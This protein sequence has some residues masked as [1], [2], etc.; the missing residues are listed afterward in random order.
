MYVTL[1]FTRLLQMQNIFDSASK[2]IQCSVQVA[3]ELALCESSNC[4]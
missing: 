4:D 1:Y 2:V 3:I